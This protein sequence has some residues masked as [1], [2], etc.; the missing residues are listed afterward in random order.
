MAIFAKLFDLDSTHQVLVRLEDD[1]EDPRTYL[2]LST[3][4]EGVQIEAKIGYDKTEKAQKAF[5]NYQSADA[6]QFFKQIQKDFFN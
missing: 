2:I 3:D 4:V 6:F 1:S 5:D